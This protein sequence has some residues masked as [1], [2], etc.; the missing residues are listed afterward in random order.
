MNGDNKSGAVMA[1]QKETDMKPQITE[2]CV[3]I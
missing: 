2:E 1:E 3:Y